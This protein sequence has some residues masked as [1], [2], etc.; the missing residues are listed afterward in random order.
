MKVERKLLYLK[1]I[2]L[3]F[4]S[5]SFKTNQARIPNV[6]AMIAT[7]STFANLMA[8]DGRHLNFSKVGAVAKNS[9]PSGSNLL[10]A[11]HG[12]ITLAASLPLTW[13]QTSV[14]LYLALKSVDVHGDG[15]VGGGW[16]DPQH[17]F[18]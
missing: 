13:L 9:Q 10:A 16:A 15:A 12:I 6:I 5:I 1:I 3:Y 11:I 14:S 2:F 8:L 7:E 18:G 17:K 4:I